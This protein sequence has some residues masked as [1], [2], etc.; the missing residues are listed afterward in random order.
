MADFLSRHP[1]YFIK[2]WTVVDREM[3]DGSGSDNK[4]HLKD[5]NGKYFPTQM[6]WKSF[7]YGPI[8]VDK[9]RATFDLSEINL[10]K[11]NISIDDDSV[12]YNKVVGDT[13]EKTYYGVVA[14]R[15]IR[16]SSSFF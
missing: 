8:W 6:L 13:R 7:D 4:K 2:Q 12:G 14:N 11:N 16:E 3:F 15:K 9:N 5:E 1:F 10:G